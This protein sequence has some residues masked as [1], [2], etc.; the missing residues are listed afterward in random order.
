MKKKRWIK[1]FI[2]DITLAVHLD[3]NMDH[4]CKSRNELVHGC[5][6]ILKF[7]EK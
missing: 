2:V 4:Y 3:H 1:C 6:D 7:I 5:R